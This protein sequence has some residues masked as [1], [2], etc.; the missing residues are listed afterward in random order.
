MG[1]MTT[2]IMVPETNGK[3]SKSFGQTGPEVPKDVMLILAR[4]NMESLKQKALHDKH[5]MKTGAIT[6]DMLA[7]YVPDAVSAFGRLTFCI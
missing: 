5:I 6:P 7:D 4:D 3:R 1:V 2:T